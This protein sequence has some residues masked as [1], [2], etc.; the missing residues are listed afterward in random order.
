MGRRSQVPSPDARW[1]GVPTPRLPPPLGSPAAEPAYREQGWIPGRTA[2]AGTGD[3]PAPRLRLP[4]PRGLS[5]CGGAEAVPTVQRSPDGLSA[6]S[7]PG[8]PHPQ[9]PQ[10]WGETDAINSPAWAQGV[11]TGRGGRPRGETEAQTLEGIRGIRGK[12]RAKRT[13]GSKKGPTALPVASASAQGCRGAE[14]AGRTD[15]QMDGQI[16]GPGGG[17]LEV[18][19]AV[20]G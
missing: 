15:G 11:G 4:G 7:V 9:A 18:P 20:W 6:D 19:P 12:P 3:A 16:D 14:R 5:L 17:V 10:L 8:P 13:W 2:G 1:D